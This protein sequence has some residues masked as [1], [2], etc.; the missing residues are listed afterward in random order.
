[1]LLNKPQSMGVREWLVKTLSLR[2]HTPESIISAVVVH[3]FDQAN[4][5]LKEEDSL[6]ISGFGKFYYNRKKA[7]KEM[8]KRLSQKEVFQKVLDDETISA[9]K[10]HS[11]ELQMI[12][13]DNNIKALKLKE[14]K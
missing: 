14:K 2:I 3:Q 11:Y 1:M 6:E 7:E 12:T 13:I 9:K 10:R 4:I 5:K 8:V